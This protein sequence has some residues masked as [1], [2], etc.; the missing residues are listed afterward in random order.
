MGAPAALTT[1]IPDRAGVMDILGETG[2][3]LRLDD[4]QKGAVNSFDEARLTR[5]FSLATD[6][7]CNFYLARYDSTELASNWTVY[8]WCCIF[9]AY[10]LCK[11]RGNQAPGSLQ[12]LYDETVAMLERLQSGELYLAQVAQRGSPSLSMSNVRLDGRYHTK[13]LRVE[14]SISDT[15]RPKHDQSH[16]WVSEVVPEPIP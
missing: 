14:G 9:A 15:I 13:Q 16:D 2:T 1:V 4:D 10:R 7:V 12:A 8:D 5:L 11:R 3:N 6:K